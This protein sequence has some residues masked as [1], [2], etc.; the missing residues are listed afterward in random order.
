MNLTEWFLISLFRSFG[1]ELNIT[2]WKTWN[3]F[4]NTYTHLNFLT[5]S[6]GESISRK[7][8][9]QFTLWNSQSGFLCFLNTCVFAYN[10]IS[11][12]AYFWE[13]KF[14]PWR[15]TK[16]K[17]LVNCKQLWKGKALQFI[18]FFVFAYYTVCPKSM[19]YN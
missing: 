2:V 19:E 15:C 4:S 1:K 5:F 16:Y 7:V 6:F 17:T 3:F 12:N 9:G 8:L 10:V 18:L 14:I 11:R 13:S